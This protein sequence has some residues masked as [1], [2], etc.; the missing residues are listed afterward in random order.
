MMETLFAPVGDYGVFVRSDTNVED[1]PGF[2]GAGLNR[3]VAN[4]VD[5]EK[6]F[7]AIPL[8]W[9][10]PYTERAMA[11]RSGILERPEEVYASVL[12]MKASVAG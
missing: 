5:R 4:L 1:L 11:W 2:T 7:V 9:S 10:S 3:T 12:L 6:V 8:V